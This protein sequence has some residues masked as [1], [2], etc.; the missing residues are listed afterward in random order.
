MNSKG[1]EQVLNHKDT[2]DI[3]KG[4]SGLTIN[5]EKF[6]N[7]RKEDI[8]ALAEELEFYRQQRSLAKGGV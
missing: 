1:G 8:Q 6:V 3:L 4:S 2:K 5:I 7:N